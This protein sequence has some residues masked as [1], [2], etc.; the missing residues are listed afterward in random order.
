MQG[1]HVIFMVSTSM[2]DRYAKL[3]SDVPKKW[4]GVW[5]VIETQ[6]SKRAITKNDTCFT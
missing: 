6:F 1:M 5:N 3:N 4:I 2:E